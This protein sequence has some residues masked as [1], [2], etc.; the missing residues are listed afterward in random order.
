MLHRINPPPLSPSLRVR[1]CVYTVNRL[2]VKIS[3]SHITL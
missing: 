1:E 3:I 2:I